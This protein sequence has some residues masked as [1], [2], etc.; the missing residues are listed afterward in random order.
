MTEHGIS[1]EAWRSAVRDV[2]ADYRT[3]M[4]H[5]NKALDAMYHTEWLVRGIGDEFWRKTEGLIT[6]AHELFVD[7]A[8]LSRGVG[9]AT[10]D[11]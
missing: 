8:A 2:Q 7:L 6:T 11:D 1:S 4:Q 10:P 9:E 3:A 5:V